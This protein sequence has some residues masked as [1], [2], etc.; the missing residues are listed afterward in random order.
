[1]KNPYSNYFSLQYAN[2]DRQKKYLEEYKKMFEWNSKY[3]FSQIKDKKKNN[4]LDIGCGLGQNLYTLT[5]LGYKNVIGIDISDDSIKFCKKHKFNVFKISAEEFV[6]KHKNE[7]DVITI[8]HV[9]EHINKKEIIKFLNGLRNSLAPGGYLIINIPNGSNPIAAVHDRY[10][11]LTH[12]ILYTP[13][14]MTEILNMAGFERENISIKELVGYTPFGKNIFEKILK[15]VI[16]P[17]L[18]ILVDGVWNIFY[19][20]QGASPKKNRPAL[21][22]IARK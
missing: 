1:M 3:I 2:L 11:D 10:V 8:Y 7:F 9:V 4:A 19:L 17:I 20:S 21:V 18:T 22:S 12:E 14:S 16:L 15:R 5:K 13:E 6:K